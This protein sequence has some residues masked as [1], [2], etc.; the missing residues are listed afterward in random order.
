M[1][2]LYVNVA[3]AG[4]APCH[5]APEVRQGTEGSFGP[6]TSKETSFCKHIAQDGNAKKSWDLPHVLETETPACRCRL[7]ARNVETCPPGDHVSFRPSTLPHAHLDKL[8]WV[9]RKAVCFIDCFFG[10]ERSSR[11]TDCQQMWLE[12][13]MH[14]R[15]VRQIS[16]DDE[17]TDGD[18]HLFQG[19]PGRDIPDQ[20]RTRRRRRFAVRA[21][22]RPGVRILG[23]APTG[24]KPGAR[25]RAL[26]GLP[27]MHPPSAEPR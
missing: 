12:T 10:F 23:A 17:N 24:G 27:S 16:A 3:L 11:Q 26:W 21:G 6:S 5:G 7:S 14:G 22:K 18:N 20:L 2:V 13:V 4:L 19:A 15:S 9:E 25:P 1:S 8:A